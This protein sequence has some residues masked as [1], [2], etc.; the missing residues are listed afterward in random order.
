MGPIGASDPADL[1]ALLDEVLRRSVELGVELVSFEVPMSNGSA[2]R[3]LLE[4]GLRI[5]P[6]LTILLSNREFGHMDRYLA[7]SPPIFL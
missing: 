5:D 6:F 2:L 7:Y 3:H 1:P 4:R